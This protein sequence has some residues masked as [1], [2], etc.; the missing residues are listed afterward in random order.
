MRMNIYTYDACVSSRTISIPLWPVYPF[1][2]RLMCAFMDD[3]HVNRSFVPKIKLK[4]RN[5]LISH[6]IRSRFRCF[7]FTKNFWFRMAT[8]N[9]PLDMDISVNASRPN[10]IN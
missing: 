5:N 7:G 9:M 8:F 4:Q 2:S 6:S 3:E 10:R 1:I